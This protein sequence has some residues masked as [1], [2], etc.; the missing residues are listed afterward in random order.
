MIGFKLVSKQWKS[1]IES[2][3]FVIGHSN[4]HPQLL[5]CPI[6]GYRE[7]TSFFNEKYVFFLDDGKNETL[8]NVSVSNVISKNI[9]QKFS[10]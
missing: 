8:F 1:F 7:D 6:I 3:D 2:S 10:I 9:E 5:S 4:R